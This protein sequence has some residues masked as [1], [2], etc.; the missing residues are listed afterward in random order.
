MS[1]ILQMLIVLILLGASG[2]FV[3]R[4]F[5]RGRQICTTSSDCSKCDPEQ[6]PQADRSGYKTTPL[7]QLPSAPPKDLP[8]Q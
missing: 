3:L 1:D 4:H 7:V 6:G 8:R 5:L 2:F